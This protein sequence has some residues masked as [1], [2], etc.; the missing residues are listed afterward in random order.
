MKAFIVSFLFDWHGKKP[1]NPDEAIP[2]LDK[3]LHKHTT[4]ISDITLKTINQN[5]Y[6]FAFLY[7]FKDFILPEEIQELMEMILPEFSFLVHDIKVKEL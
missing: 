4:N 5:L 1:I 6:E 3:F 7:N 2:V